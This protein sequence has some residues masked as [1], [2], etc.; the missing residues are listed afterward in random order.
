MSTIKSIAELFNL[1]IDDDIPIK[2]VNRVPSKP[3]YNYPIT[4]YKAISIAK[5][6]LTKEYLKEWDS[7]PLTYISLYLDVEKVIEYNKN[8]YYYIIATGGDISGIDKDTFW[9]GEISKESCKK[10]RCLVDV[11]NGGYI[12]LKDKSIK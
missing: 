6:E 11:N 8:L 3:Q 4:D 9:D 10:L 1:N 7:T 5:K 2:V 12:Y